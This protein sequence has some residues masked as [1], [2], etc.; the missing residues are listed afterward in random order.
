MVQKKI[1][2]RRAWGAGDIDVEALAGKLLVSPS[3]LRG[4]LAQVR[5]G[6]ISGQYLSLQAQALQRLVNTL[7]TGWVNIE[8]DDFRVADFEQ[9]RSFSTDS[10][11]VTATGTTFLAAW[12]KG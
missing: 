4:I 5:F 9:V 12:L 8:S 3:L 10:A 11:A 7:T 6:G 2:L 1:R